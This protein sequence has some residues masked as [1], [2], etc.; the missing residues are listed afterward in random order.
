[1]FA[2]GKLEEMRL[3]QIAR[4][5]DSKPQEIRKFILDQFKV[6]LDADPNTK[7]DDDQVN[8]ILEHF[9]K[10]EVVESVEKEEVDDVIEEV[11]EDVIDPTVDTDIE[12]LKE[13]AE[14]EAANVK[15]EIPDVKSEEEDSVTEDKE[16][17][18]PTAEEKAKKVVEIKHSEENEVTEEDPTSFEEVEVDH[19]ADV[20]A[21]KVDKLDGLKV[22]GKIDLSDPEPE[23]ED[24]PTAD[25]IEDEIDQLDGDVDTSEYPDLTENSTDEDK[26][27]IF[28]ELDAQMDEN[29][30]VKK[31]KQ[32]TNEASEVN[33]NIEVEDDENSIYKNKR[34]DYRFTREQR[35]NRAKSLAV[36][37]EKQ[38]VKALKEKKKRHYEE[39]V[40]A[41]V[42]PKSKKKKNK[43]SKKAKSKE[44]QEEPKGLWQKF[45]NWLND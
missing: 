1:M 21:A 35:E 41:K 13:I 26:E 17:E 15:L 8:A 38:R 6:E 7:L 22:V 33:D 16:E 9:K 23:E 11:E 29:K 32:V 3:A 18:Q 40:A 37:A 27:A 31:V 24:L 42:K 45:L 20:I 19:E 43:P 10:E 34:G 36:K 44:Q 14:E 28:A 25:A 12:A 30:G 4:K 5:V 2:K 39:N